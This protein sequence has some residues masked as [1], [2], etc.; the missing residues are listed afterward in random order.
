M[1]AFSREELAKVQNIAPEYEI[2]DIDKRGIITLHPKEAPNITVSSSV[3][4]EKS[5][6]ST[7]IRLHVDRGTWGRFKRVVRERG[8]TVCRAI[9]GYVQKVVDRDELLLEP[10]EFRMVTVFERGRGPRHSSEVVCSVSD[11]TSKTAIPNA[12]EAAGTEAQEANTKP[13]S[14]DAPNAT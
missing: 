9:S 2:F 6:V 5:S 8:S 11:S 7:S 13:Q 14:A 4:V 3:D 1:L 12:E 10:D